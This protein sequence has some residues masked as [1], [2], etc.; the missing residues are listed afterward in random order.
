M[1]NQPEIL[2]VFWDVDGVIIESEPL[3]VDKINGTAAK[4]NLIVTEDDWKEWHG[5][6]D[7]RIYLK[8]KD[9]GLEISEDQFLN[10]CFAYYKGNKD[11]LVVRK[12]FKEAFQIVANT[13]A[14]Q[15]AIT[16]GVKEQLDV[17]LS[18]A[19]IQDQLDFRMDANDIVEK[20]LKT[21]PAPDPYLAALERTNEIRAARGLPPIEPENCVIIEDSPSGIMSGDN[22]SMLTVHWRLSPFHP[23]SNQADYT[24]VDARQF[25]NVM[26][27]IM[28]KV[29]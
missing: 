23:A 13:G 2:A 8:L 17:N 1:T 29:A 21:K 5:I 16:N 22:A 14:I 12:G 15:A 24:A 20:G 27:N 25:V 11:R 26:R 4:Y 28:P 7:H 18:V 10:E 19:G 3:H 6:G 9:R